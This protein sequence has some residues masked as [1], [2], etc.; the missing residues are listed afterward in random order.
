VITPNQEIKCE[1]AQNSG[2]EQA[3]VPGSTSTWHLEA[4][5][6]RIIASLRGRETLGEKGWH[7]LPLAYM[8]L[9]ACGPAGLWLGLAS[10]AREVG[11][12]SLIVGEAGAGRHLSALPE[13]TAIERQSERQ[14][15]KKSRKRRNFK[16]V[17]ASV[18]TRLGD[19]ARHDE[20]RSCID[21]R[22]MASSVVD[23]G[24][25]EMGGG[26]SAHLLSKEAEHPKS[27]TGCSL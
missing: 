8:G 19:G 20:A 22:P 10:L 3:D 23:L 15:E 5:S 11:H 13:D 1:D 4:A 24:V 21:K 12:P 14:R 16:K 17:S 26:M 6:H 25:L 9:W 27:R 7:A 18:E 2:S